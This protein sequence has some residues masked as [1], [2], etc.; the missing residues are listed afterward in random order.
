MKREL[1]EIIKEIQKLSVECIIKNLYSEDYE[2]WK[3]K[4]LKSQEYDDLNYLVEDARKNAINFIVE[5]YK[6]L[7]MY[8]SKDREYEI[9]DFKTFEQ[10]FNIIKDKDEKAKID[11][12]L[13]QQTEIFFDKLSKQ[14]SED[15]DRTVNMIL[16][17]DGHG[18]DTAKIS[19]P[20]KWSRELGFSKEKRKARIIK[21]GNKIIIEKEEEM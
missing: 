20:I 4:E 9:A 2:K 17:K 16:G 12:E 21:K 5:K 14:L 11:L 6:N 18:S 1:S 10:Y 15:E 19:I 7:D 3:N 8:H 13:K